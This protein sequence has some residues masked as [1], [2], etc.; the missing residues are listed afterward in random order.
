MKAAIARTSEKQRRGWSSR[1]VEYVTALPVWINS[2]TVLAF[3][4]MDGE[5]DTTGIIEKALSEQKTVAIPR[6]YGDE[7]RF[8]RIKSLAGPWEVHRYGIREPAESSPIVN[9]C[10]E[11][12][13][14]VIVITPGLCFDSKGRRLGFGRGYY[15]RLLNRCRTKNSGNVFSVAV[16]FSLQLIE[17]VPA[18]T[19][20]CP[21]DAIVTENGVILAKPSA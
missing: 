11:S 7:I 18:D 16:C 14:N 1:I 17:R 5:I 15:D 12:S 21:V 13:G 10:A 4:S 9:P 19:H 3:L 6:M 20:D 8:H 2:N